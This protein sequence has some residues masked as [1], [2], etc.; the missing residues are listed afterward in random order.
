MYSYYTTCISRFCFSSKSSHSWAWHQ[1]MFGIFVWWMTW[2][3]NWWLKKSVRFM[4]MDYSANHFSVQK[5]VPTLLG[6]F[7]SLIMSPCSLKATSGQSVWSLTRQRSVKE[8]SSSWWLQRRGEHQQQGVPFM[9]SLQTTPLHSSWQTE[10]DGKRG[11][12]TTKT[13][14]VWEE[15]GYFWLST[16]MHSKFLVCVLSFFKADHKWSSRTA[17]LIFSS[18]FSKSNHM[19]SHITQPLFFSFI[20]SYLNSL[21]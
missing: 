2:T 3:F 18:F 11:G 20:N 19:W 1:W 12:E 21:W 7:C 5:R 14:A 8:R 17:F 9:F 16:K 15:C 13:N 10:G 6:F 4:F